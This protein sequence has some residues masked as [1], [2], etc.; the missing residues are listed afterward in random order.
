MADL[1]KSEGVSVKEIETF[2]KNHRFEL[3]FLFAIIFAAVFS[4]VFFNPGWSIFC[5]A[6]GSLVGGFYPVKT[7]QL[8]RT[9]F[10]FVLKQEQMIQI[11]LG[12]VLLILAIFL[13]F[14]IFATLGGCGG[15]K[16]RD[17]FKKA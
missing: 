11:V 9:V 14:V 13:P 17:L 10:Q 12:S 6:I 1:K 4:F 5:G 2:A 15:M 3:F 7:E 16:I 8:F